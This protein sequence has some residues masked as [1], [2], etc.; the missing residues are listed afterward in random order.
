MALL[1]L[2]EEGKVSL[3]YAP[4]KSRS[5]RLSEVDTSR[6]T[7]PGMDWAAWAIGIS[8]MDSR[9]IMEECIRIFEAKHPKLPDRDLASA[10]EQEALLDLV[11][12]QLEP[13]IMDGYRRFVM[14]VETRNDQSPESNGVSEALSIPHPHAELSRR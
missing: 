1:E 7:D 6:T 14:V 9:E 11:Q 8:T 5:P 3:L 4:P 2:I 10:V 13:V 12:M